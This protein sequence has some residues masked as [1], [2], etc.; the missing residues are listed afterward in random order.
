M[1]KMTKKQ[2]AERCKKM[3]N[4]Y[5]KLIV[6]YDPVVIDD[7]EDVEFLRELLKNHPTKS[8]AANARQFGVGKN[9]FLYKMPRAHSW[10]GG[11]SYM[12][13]ITVVKHSTEVKGA[14]RRAV[15]DQIKEFRRA[16]FN[17]V[18]AMSGEPLDYSDIHVDHEN[19]TFLQLFNSFISDHGIEVDAVKLADLDEGG[20]ELV[21]SEL[22]TLWQDYHKKHAKLRCISSQENLR[23]KRT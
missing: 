21:D 2:L 16:N 23:R 7:K 5:Q 19:P 13:C 9:C 10:N 1:K 14:F 8:E 4:K 12:K 15:N 20:K 11:F 6:K 18:S 22:I 3:L 17:G